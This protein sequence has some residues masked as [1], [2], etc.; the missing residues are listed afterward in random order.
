MTIPKMRIPYFGGPVDGEIEHI[1]P[2]DFAA[3][4]EAWLAGEPQ[5]A[6]VY[7]LRKHWHGHYVLS[8]V[9]TL[10]GLPDNTFEKGER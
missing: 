1:P 10:P 6:E 9:G 4:I 8:W 7:Q 2:R 5:T 3:D